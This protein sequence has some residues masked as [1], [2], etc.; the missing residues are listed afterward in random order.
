MR[1]AHLALCTLDD[2]VDDLSRFACW[3]MSLCIYKCE[4]GTHQGTSIIRLVIQGLTNKRKM[5]TAVMS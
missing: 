3:L 1:T 2:V 5:K 4:C